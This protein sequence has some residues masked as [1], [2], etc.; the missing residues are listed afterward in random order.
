MLLFFLCKIM[1]RSGPGKRHGS[2][3]LLPENAFL[4]LLIYPLTHSINETKLNPSSLQPVTMGFGIYVLL[5][6]ILFA[7]IMP[8]WQPCATHPFCQISA[9]IFH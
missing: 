2:L 9:H 5:A 8:C 7:N 1:C 4:G 3:Q 6:K